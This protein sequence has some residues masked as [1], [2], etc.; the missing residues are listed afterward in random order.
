MLA[1]RRFRRL[2]RDVDNRM[3]GVTKIGQ[4][5]KQSRSQS[6]SQEG[7]MWR[8]RVL[9]LVIMLML[10]VPV[11]LADDRF[12]DVLSDNPFHDQ[13]SRVATVGLATGFPDGTYRRND[14]VTRGQM[15][16]FMGRM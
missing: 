13:I 2:V 11:A 5:V 1:G 3:R 4:Q 14:P 12:S 10:A 15:A 16:N 6:R 8:K 7:K 9:A